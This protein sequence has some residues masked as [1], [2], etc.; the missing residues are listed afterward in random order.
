[1]QHPLQPD[2]ATQK[3]QPNALGSTVLTSNVHTRSSPVTPAPARVPV[4][5][6][7]S[8]ASMLLLGRSALI[9]IE[10]MTSPS[11]RQAFSALA[12][13]ASGRRVLG[14][15]RRP[16]RENRRSPTGTKKESKAEEQDMCRAQGPP[17]PPDNARFSL[18][19]ELG[20]HQNATREAQL[21]ARAKHPNYARARATRSHRGAA[22]MTAS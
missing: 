9:S 22:A 4:G 18:L 5:T 8:N 1:M 17:P 10:L 15:K 13:G 14:A 12:A 16:S 3:T 6:C 21:R 20:P 11:R 2:G 7:R 19:R